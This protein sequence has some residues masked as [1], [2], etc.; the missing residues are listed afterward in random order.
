MLV[1]LN[2][3]LAYLRAIAGV[4]DYDRYLEYHRRNNSTEPPMCAREF[5]RKANDEKYGGDGVR[6]CC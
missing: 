3:V 1:L 5:H 6:R 4:P 2:K